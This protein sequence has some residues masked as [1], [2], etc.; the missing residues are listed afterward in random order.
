M[1]NTPHD[2]YI[3]TAKHNGYGFGMNQWAKLFSCIL[4]SSVWLEA[5]PTR[6]VWITLLAMKDSEGRVGASVPGLAH[7]ARVTLDECK[8]A[9]G[10][11]LAPDPHSTSQEHSGRRIQAIEG[12]W[13]VLNHFKYRDEKADYRKE[14]NRR[15]QAEYRARKKQFV[16]DPKTDVPVESEAA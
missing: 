2:V 10:T 8:T 9:L 5:A 6:L 1:H 13:V 14:Y 15:K 12:G 7:A 11:F 16:G 3:D 4:Q